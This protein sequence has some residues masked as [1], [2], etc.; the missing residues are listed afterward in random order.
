[1]TLA[2]IRHQIE[3]TPLRPY[4]ILIIALGVLVNMLDGYDILAL[5]LISPILTREWTLSPEA[6]G[7]LFSASLLGMAAGALLLSPIADVYGR[8][9]AIMIN[10][11]LMSIGMLLS[12]QASSVPMLMVMR[13]CTGLGV[14]AMASCVG[15]LIFEYCSLKT[16][17][18][19]LGFVT[20]GYTVGTLLG[21]YAAPWLLQVLDWRGVFVFGGLCSC[22]L[23]PIIY[24]LLPESLDVLVARQTPKSL[25]TINKIL[26][27]MQ[28][29]ALSALPAPQFKAAASNLI[30]LFRQPILSRTILMAL[31]YFLYM[32]TQYFFLN[33]NNQLTV[34]AGFADT[35][36]LMVSR[37]T[38][39]GG[40][41]GGIVIGIASVRF[42]IRPVSVVTL[43]LMGLSLVV[44]GMAASNLN[45]AQA[46][47]FVMGFCIFGAAVVLYSHGATTFP[48]RVRATGMGMVM[49]AGRLGSTF[50][51]SAAGVLL[52]AG[53]TRLAVCAIL[54]IPVLLS[55]FTLVKVPLTPVSE[56]KAPAE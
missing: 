10:L 52:G 16:R 51:P 33:W 42:P 8:R 25:V 41:V 36:G 50:G 45:L 39:F 43:V 27:R 19:G 3:N 30:D 40:I 5:S 23:I 46:S 54:A 55:I 2:A 34:N 32:F 18:L 12:S 24:F 21:T 31:S 37:L 15:T 11:G 28:L 48:A 20:I 7:L 44:F 6:L 47:A 29:P 4:Q 17:S 53:Q 14:G 49:S 56:Q 9:T 22:V 1:M 26:G 13:F 38:S 35:D